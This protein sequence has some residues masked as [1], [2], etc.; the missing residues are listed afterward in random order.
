[1]K[2]IIKNCIII[3]MLIVACSAKAQG[4]PLSASETTA[5]VNNVIKP[6]LQRNHVPGAAVIIYNHGVPQ[7]FYFGTATKSKRNHVNANTVFEIASVTKVF[8]SLLLAYEFN[9]GQVKLNDPVV[10]YLPNAPRNNPSLNRVTMQGLATHVLGL[11]QMPPNYVKNRQQFMRSLQSWR[12][13]YALNSWWKYTN[14]GFGLLGYALETISHKSYVALLK[15]A[16]L[17]PLQMTDTNLTGSTCFN[18]AQG[19]SWNGKPV[20]TTKALRLIPGAG[21]VRSSG[22]DM[23]KFLAASLNIPGTPPSVA[24]AFRVTQMPFYRT[25]YGAQGL[26]WEIHS[27]NTL[28]KDGYIHGQVRTL[29]LHSSAAYP[30]RYPT[31]LRGQVMYDKTGSVAGFRAYIAVVPASQ[32]GIVIMVNSAMPRTQLV[33]ASR[34]VLLSMIRR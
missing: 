29:T 30:V 18:C 13:P 22:C 11:G 19:Y 27:F 31:P 26:G 9:Q 28:G 20:N 1:M 21:S 2:L 14:V 8:T 25:A 12:P 15:E 34:K 17:D 32:T 10:P 4:R 6:V 24:A 23:Q 33:V 7:S 16:I 5:L 3:A